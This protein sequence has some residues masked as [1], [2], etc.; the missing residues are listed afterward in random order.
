MHS[1]IILSHVCMYGCCSA[2][3]YLF[4]KFEYVADVMVNIKDILK[5][6][7]VDL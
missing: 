3:S 2:N 6:R 5:L 1:V 4:E 7:R